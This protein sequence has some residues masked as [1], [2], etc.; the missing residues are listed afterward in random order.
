VSC[1]RAADGGL[2]GT[3][4]AVCATINTTTISAADVHSGNA[5]GQAVTLNTPGVISNTMSTGTDSTTGNLYVGLSDG[6]NGYVEI[7][8]Y[9]S[10]TLGFYKT[11]NYPGTIVY[12]VAS[13]QG[14]VFV[15]AGSFFNGQSIN[16][17]D[18]QTCNLS[19]LAHSP[20][21]VKG[22]QSGPGGQCVAVSSQN[23]IYFVDDASATLYQYNYVSNTFTN[24]TMPNDF[25]SDAFFYLYGS[26]NLTFLVYHA[27]SFSATSNTYQIPFSTM[28][29]QVANTQSLQDMGV[30]DSVNPPNL[31]SFSFG[32]SVYSFSGNMLENGPSLQT[33]N[34]IGGTNYAYDSHTTQYGAN[35]HNDAS[36]LSVAVSLLFAAI[37][38][39]L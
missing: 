35:S 32:S 38:A 24:Y 9:T 34:C 12:C 23:S 10:T 13:T 39:L 17:L 2:E 21:N 36:S 3:Y 25:Y 15:F 14:S 26:N 18:L 16:R 37:I 28:T 27:Q 4:F 19:Y 33:A 31:L 1:C 7:F 30:D 11:C 20:V 6:T 8:N 29:P 5:V 22:S